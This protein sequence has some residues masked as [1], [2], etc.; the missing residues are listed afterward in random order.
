MIQ[1]RTSAQA[2]ESLHS[3]ERNIILSSATSI[4]LSFEHEIAHSLEDAISRL[5]DYK[6]FFIIGGETIFRQ[7]MELADEMVLTH[8]EVE[9]EGDAYFPKFDQSEWKAH[10]L[11][12]H[13]TD[14]DHAYSFEV[15][16]WVR[17]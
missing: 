7:S 4:D 11:S 3:N 16:R 5:S 15:I 6:Q 13:E 14:Q 8:V 1:G 10:L 2:T 17:A 12:R 9:V